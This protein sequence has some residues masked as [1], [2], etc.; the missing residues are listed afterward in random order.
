MPRGGHHAQPR[1][2]TTD[3][4]HVT[5]RG[6]LLYGDEHGGITVAG[7]DHW[8]ASPERTTA[9]RALARWCEEAIAGSPPPTPGPTEPPPVG[10]EPAGTA[11][12]ATSGP[13]ITP[14]VSSWKCS[15]GRRIG[16]RESSFAGEDIGPCACYEAGERAVSAQNQHEHHAQQDDQQQTHG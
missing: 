6:A 4:W 15:G 5:E 2:E 16:T 7:L 9:I 3:H 10:V 12:N 8:P 14:P 1:R 13:L 11:C